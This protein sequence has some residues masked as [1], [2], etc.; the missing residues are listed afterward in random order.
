EG[1]FHRR[2]S[3]HE[4]KAIIKHAYHSGIRAFDTAYSY[5]EADS[6]LSAALREIHAPRDGVTI[7]SKVMP[8]PTLERKAYA[9]LRRLG[10]D[11]F[12]ILLI[13]W[14]S[15]EASIFSSLRAL[16]RLKDKGIAR[17]IGV[18][19]FTPRLLRKYSSDFDISY[20]ERALSILWN[21]G[22]DEEREMGIRTIAYSPLCMGLLADREID[23]RRSSLELCKAP[24]FP[25]AMES[26]RKLA[27]D[28]GMR[29]EELAI[30]Y[31]YSKGASFVVSGA[32]SPEQLSLLDSARELDGDT[33]SALDGIGHVIAEECTSDN[34]FSHVY[35]RI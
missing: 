24:S 27:R 22:W 35:D 32:S 30:S 8:V 25:K 12:D 2:L 7:I 1:L 31:A 15:D 11:F 17:E 20:H 13:H 21:K 34:I 23:D 5:R 9:S 28:N 26:I 10:T 19:N 29:T 3:G 4:A 6:Y 18:S 14:P 16:E 33:L